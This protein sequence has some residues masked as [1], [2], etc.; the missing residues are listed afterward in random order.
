MDEVVGRGG[1][2]SHSDSD[3]DED[4]ERFLAAVEGCYG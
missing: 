3:V 4:R 2:C 1:L